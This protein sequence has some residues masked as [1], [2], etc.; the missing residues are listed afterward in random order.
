MTDQLELDWLTDERPAP[1]PLDPSTTMQTR[2][3]LLSY[4]TKQRA[5]GRRDRIR[6]VRR[7]TL[8]IAASSVA[9]AGVGCVALLA[10]QSGGD[11]PGA[12][13]GVLSVQ[14]ASAK[15]LTHLSAKLASAPA[16][17]GDATLVLRSQDYPSG[18]SITGA[19]LYADN[20]NYYYSPA[21]SGLA[22]AIQAGQTVNS[23]GSDGEVRDIAAAKAALSGPI[24]TAR[25]QMSVAAY[26]PNAKSESVS[27]AEAQMP[28]LERQKLQQAQQQAAANNVQ[29]VISQEDGMIWDNA[30]DALLAGAGDPQ[31]RAGVLKLLATIP[32]I[33]VTNGTLN[34]AQTLV[35]TASLLKDNSGLYQEQVVLN[36]NTG[37]PLELIGGYQRQAPTVTVQ[38]KVSRVTVAQ[39]ENGNT[40]S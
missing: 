22:A 10:T 37:V 3:E 26:D 6:R 19:D 31:V 21:P 14:N 8:R 28:A 33:T 36:A 39:V 32:Q 24:D 11:Q 40:G 34:G 30:N 2:T 29:P 13:L 25:Q 5:G 12:G 9:L 27:A 23:D 4:T 38:Y 17:V 15:Q 18:S 1:L 35:L 7:R 16:P 20:G